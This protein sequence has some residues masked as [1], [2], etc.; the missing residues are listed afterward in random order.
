MEFPRSGI[1]ELAAG[2][3][4]SIEISSRVPTFRRVAIRG[5]S[6]HRAVRT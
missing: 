1:G 4:A 5:P 6:G 2:S 3:E